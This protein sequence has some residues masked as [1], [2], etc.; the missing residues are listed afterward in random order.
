MADE[1]LTENALRRSRDYVLGMMADVVADLLYYDH[2]KELPS[3]R[4]QLLLEKGLLTPDQ[5]ADAF[6]AALLEALRR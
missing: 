3:G 4:V 5:I 2:D 1:G 6:R